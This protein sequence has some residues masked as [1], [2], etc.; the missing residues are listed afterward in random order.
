MSEPSSPVTAPGEETALVGSEDSR[1]VSGTPTTGS[2]PAV[3]VAVPK[4]VASVESSVG[5]QAKRKLRN[6]RLG[7]E[8]EIAK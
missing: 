7:T 2:E 4:R 8:Y 5:L 3:D 6:Q 1:L